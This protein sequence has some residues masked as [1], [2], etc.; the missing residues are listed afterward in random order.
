MASNL[1]DKINSYPIEVGLE[2]A[3][4]YN[5]TPVQT[6]SVIITAQG[7]ATTGVSPVMQTG[8]APVGGSNSWLF[9]LNTFASRI[10]TTSTT[11]RQ[12]FDDRNYSLGYWIKFASLNI[13][14]GSVSTTFTVTPPNAAG[15]IVGVANA[16][17]DHFFT[18]GTDTAGGSFTPP[19]ST[20]IETNRWYYIAVRRN[21]S[22]LTFYIDAEEVLTLT[23]TNTGI[24]SGVNFGNPAAFPGTSMNISNFYAAPFATIGQIE[25]SEIYAV[26]APTITNVSVAATPLTASSELVDSATSTQAI[27]VATPITATALQTEPTIAVTIG[28]H[29]EITTSITASAILPTNIVIYVVKNINIT[30]TE[31]LNASL[32]F[33]DNIT[34][35]AGTDESFS[36]AEFTA[37]AELIDPILPDPPMTASATMPNA[38]VYVTPNYYSLVKSKNPYIYYYDGGGTSTAVN[39]GYQTGTLTRGTQTLVLQDS[40]NPMQIVGNGKSWR[41]SSTYNAQNWFRFNSPDLSTSFGQVLKTGEYSVEMWINTGNPFVF[42][43]FNNFTFIGNNLYEFKNIWF[44]SEGLTFGPYALYNANGGY[45]NGGF[46]MTV[47]TGPTTS[48]TF[49]GAFNSIIANNWQQIVVRSY[50]TST[51]GRQI[52][53]WQ[54]G[55]VILSGTYTMSSWT[56]TSTQVQLGANDD[57]NAGGIYQSY[58]D[59]WALYPTVLTNTDIASHYNFI[60]TLSPDVTFTAPSLSANAEIQNS[61]VLAIDNAILT[62]DVVTATALIVNPTIIAQKTVNFAASVLTASAENTDVTVYYGWTIYATPAIS[63]AESVNAFRLSDVYSAYVQAN[64]APYRYVSF[65]G[66][67]SYLDY[68]TDN[69]YSVVS[70]VVGGTIVNP[71]FGINGKSAKTAGTSYITDGVILKESEWNDSWGTGQFSYHSAFWFQR[72]YDDTSTTGL[73]VLWNLNG[74]KDNQHVVLY[75]YQNK[76]HMQFNNGSGTFIEQDTTNGIDLFDYQRHFVVIEFDH[77]NPVQNTVRLYVDS[78]LK[79]TVLL[80][81]YTGET[82]NATS[83]DSGPNDELNNHPRLSV[84]CLITPFAATALPVVPTNTKLIIDEVYWDKNA[85]TQTEVTNLFNTMPGKTDKIFAA[86]PLTA[87]DEFVMPV[88]STSSILATVPL[89]A[90]TSLVQPQI[91]ADR[92]LIASATVLTATAELRDAQRVDNVNIVSDIFVATVTF[93][94]AGVRI[95][96]PGG[97][98]TLSAILPGAIKIKIGFGSFGESVTDLESATNYSQ[99]VKYLIS[100]SIIRAIP[101]MVE[102]K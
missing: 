37:T 68:G 89:T 21:G 26:G 33:G 85:I 69:D 64:I 52:E 88:I 76:L 13:P 43:A 59:E 73:R 53:L 11:F 19:D 17:G 27:I 94:D 61:Q 72:A 46:Y 23:N 50:S 20:P 25:I 101:R 87:A 24:T 31:T 91:T 58:L 66:N 30:I 22:T 96:I 98:M 14:S 6:G 29:T 100:D 45:S 55:S 51:S 4:T 90:S 65:D 42:G 9:D 5:S 34:I 63:Y 84:G 32:I 75:Q 102:V 95:T 71:D 54:N 80:G 10:R 15:N 67:D 97:P 16:G 40:G 49:K 62:G 77:T 79:M 56:P 48:Q 99:Y 44:D 1:H 2:F 82:T 70:T 92:E 78:V 86:L 38:T 28:D 8:V 39:S 12:I 3:T 74:Y 36:A 18:F 60:S 83:A 7:F 93:N 47:K 35:S 81:S 57:G 41:T